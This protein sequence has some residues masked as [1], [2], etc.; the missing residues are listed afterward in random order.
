VAPEW[1]LVRACY[2]EKRKRYVNSTTRHDSFSLFGVFFG[3]IAAIIVFILLF[4][5]A[6]MFSRMIG[7]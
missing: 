5:L 7:Y 6:P 1:R 4:T 3:L 2:F